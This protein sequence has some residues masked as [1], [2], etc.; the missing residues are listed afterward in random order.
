MLQQY[1]KVPFNSNL[2]K[3]FFSQVVNRTSHDKK[4]HIVNK[5]TG[6]MEKKYNIAYICNFQIQQFYYKGYSITGNKYKNCFR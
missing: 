3:I 1:L 4:K 2:F 5:T 6:L